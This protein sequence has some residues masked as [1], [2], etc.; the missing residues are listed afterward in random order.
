MNIL[1]NEFKK[2]I[3]ENQ[4][5]KTEG[6]NEEYYSYIKIPK[7]FNNEA[8]KITEE[9]LED[10]WFYFG[11]HPDDNSIFFGIL[12]DANVEYYNLDVETENDVRNLFSK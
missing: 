5:I 2:I 7:Q 9:N 6:N 4:M 8:Q 11:W 10:Y 12:G 1:L 3:K